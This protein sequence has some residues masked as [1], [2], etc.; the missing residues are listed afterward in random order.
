MRP[1]LLPIATLFGSLSLVSVGGANVLFPSIRRAVVDQRGW[2]DGQTFAHVF[3]ISQAAPGPN[4]MLA[5]AIG[6][7]AHGVAGLAI[8]TLAILLPTSLIAWTVGRLVQRSTGQAWII[9]ATDA[10]APLAVGLML[11]SGFIATRSAGAGIVGYG[12]SAVGAVAILRTRVNPLIIM[13]V[14]TIVYVGIRYFG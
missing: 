8:A 13:T 9:V 4:V 2:L 7:Q 14:G 5:S 12:I 1:G 10:L 3:A 6:W 11:A